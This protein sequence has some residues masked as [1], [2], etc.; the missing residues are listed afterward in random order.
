M[1]I[2]GGETISVEGEITASVIDKIRVISSMISTT[3]GILTYL[4]PWLLMIYNPTFAEFTMI[5]TLVQLILFTS[6]ACIPAF[7]T[8]R[9][10]YVDI[11]WPYGLVVIGVIILIYGEAPAWRKVMISAGY[12]VAGLRM[13]LMATMLFVK[14]GFKSEFPRYKYQRQYWRQG[15]HTIVM[16]IEILL[17]GIVN[18]TFLSLPA[19]LIG[20]NP[21]P[22]VDPLEIIALIIWCVSTILETVADLQK[23][24]FMSQQTMRGNVCKSGLWRYSRH[25]NYFFQWMVW[26]SLIIGSVPAIN[27]LLTGVEC[28]VLT[29]C[30]FYISRLMYWCLV[31]Y[32]GVKPAEYYS[33]I[34]RPSYVE[35]QRTTS[36][37]FPWPPYS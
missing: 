17:Q 6:I 5:N 20:F 12:L 22:T 15:N 29:V 19:I 1:E 26:N 18:F 16:Q 33:S 3:V 24:E 13:G 21:S 34:K 30:L 31:H 28:L 14:G 37:F 7:L 23:R 9:M 32:S 11:A 35:Y 4:V 2:E 8:K 36:R 10:S 25:P 27:L